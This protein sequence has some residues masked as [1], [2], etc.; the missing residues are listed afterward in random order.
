[1]AKRS[2]SQDNQGPEKVFKI[3][4]VRASVFLNQGQKG[5]FRTVK[6]DRRYQGEDNEWHSTAT[7][8]DAQLANVLAVGQLALAYL[9]EK[10]QA[11]DTDNGS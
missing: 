5:P 7:F 11:E 1:M 10:G 8:G 9:I 2:T 4:S 3:G 6:L